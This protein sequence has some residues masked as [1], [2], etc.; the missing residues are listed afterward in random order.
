MAIQWAS[1]RIP[2]WLPNALS[3]LRIALVPVWLVLAFEVRRLALSGGDASPIGPIVVLIAIGASDIID[4]ILARRFGLASNLGATLDAVADKIAQIA[5]VT[6]LALAAAPA[7]TPLPVWLM[8]A[9]AARDFLLGV[10]WWAVRRKRGEVNAEH[11]WHGKASSA[12]LFVLILLALA[13]IRSSIVVVGSAAVLVLVVPS[14]VAYLMT[15][16][17]QLTSHGAGK[18]A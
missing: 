7:F 11:R 1:M 6:F 4:G 16:W 12:L 10:G 14:T 5:C 15:G 18:P 9:L 13:G 17:R 8:A 3:V 2:A